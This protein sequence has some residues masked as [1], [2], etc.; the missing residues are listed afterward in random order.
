MKLLRS[1]SFKLLSVALIVVFFINTVVV[2]SDLYETRKLL[3][4]TEKESAVMHSSLILKDIEI[5][6][7]Q[8]NSG[9]LQ[10]L[11]EHAA[12]EH[13]ELHDLRLF[14]AET[15]RITASAD[16]KE[17]GTSIYAE[18]WKKFVKGEF[19]SF[20]I[21][22]GGKVFASKIVPVRNKPS[23]TGC[24]P[25]DR[26]VLG[27]IDLEISLDKAVS[28][29]KDLAIK[30]FSGLVAGFLII[31]TVFLL[32]GA[33]L[34]T[35]PLKE[36]TEGMRKVGAGDLKVRVKEGR[37]DE[38]GYLAKGFN[39]MVSSLDEAKKQIQE[40]YSHQMERASKLASIGEIV[41]GIAHEIKNPLTGISCAIQVLNAE[42][43]DDSHKK[44]VVSEILNQVKRLDRTVKDL[45]NYARAKPPQIVLTNVRNVLDKALFFVYPEARKQNVEISM[46][47]ECEPCDILID[48][49]QIQQVCLN[50]MINAVQAMSSG[51][52]LTITARTIGGE[53]FSNVTGRSQGADRAL[54]ISF[55]DTGKGI[56]PEDIPHIFEP[57]FTRKTQ[58]TG[59]GLSISHKIAQ[60]HGGD[61][62]VR[63][64]VGVSSTF[65]LYLPFLEHPAGSNASRRDIGGPIVTG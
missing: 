38:F 16:R 37:Q 10:V 6:M 4:E 34:I 30:Q 61:I 17:I 52:T 57:F 33:R 24:H 47:Y 22:K 50:L 3:V 40:L 35:R 63:S 51:G 21:E 14:S 26:P 15:G 31:L 44:A 19:Q 43:A 36:L 2:L 65:T 27:V 1:V 59:L 58:G 55:E 42:Y 5:L 48:P 60:D 23:C 41:S 32:Q 53:E 28:S 45:L 8:K 20:V 18:D 56:P 49:D 64:R 11:V 13:P 54:A 25:S 12:R 39:S 7:L 46:K 62:I 9:G 29:V